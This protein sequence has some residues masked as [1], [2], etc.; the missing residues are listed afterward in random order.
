MPETGRDTKNYPDE[1]QA[2]LGVPG[3]TGVAIVYCTFPSVT[4]ATA[5]GRALVEQRMAACVN[6]V[7]GVTA[8]YEWEGAIHEDGEVV[9]IIKTLAGRVADVFTAITALH[10]YANPALVSL[11]VRAGS[12]AY[13]AWVKAQVEAT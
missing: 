7:P 11:D 1:G 13:L 8:I 3:R 10:P 5:V 4:A 6:V 12:S 2:G 9:V